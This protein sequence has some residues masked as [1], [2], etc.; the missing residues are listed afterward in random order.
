MLR[1][2]EELML[3]LMDDERGDIPPS[4]PR[5][6]LNL[7]LAGAV[8]MDL[9]LEDRIDTDVERFVFVDAAPLGD[10]LLDPVLAEL[11]RDRAERDTAYWI[12]R[13]ASEQGENIRGTALARLA[14]RGILSPS[15]FG[16]RFFLSRRVARTRRYHIVDGEADSHI[17]LRIMR[18]LFSDAI[19]DPREVAIIALADAC[20]VFQTIL[21]KSEL[22]EAREKIDLVRQLDAI[23]RSV[24]HAVE[25]CGAVPVDDPAA[26]GRI[27]GDA[28]AP[29]FGHALTWAAT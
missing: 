6:S 8:L 4:L 15:E 11:A 17:R 5:H 25:Q 16:R 12:E 20:G 18:V 27:P 29:V 21:S 3:L 1:F 7:V 9:A 19:P 14:E 2:A 24:A 23:G 22:D 28:G 10:D 26:A 13:I